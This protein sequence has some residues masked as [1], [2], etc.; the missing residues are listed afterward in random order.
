MGNRQKRFRL[1]KCIL[2]HIR[3]SAIR[4]SRYRKWVRV[5]NR[6]YRAFALAVS[7]F[8]LTVVIVLVAS[9]FFDLD[10]DSSGRSFTLEILLTDPFL[11]SIAFFFAAIAFPDLLPSRRP[12]LSNAVAHSLLYTL[13]IPA[14]KLITG[15]PR[16][17]LFSIADSRQLSMIW[18]HPAALAVLF[19]FEMGFFW[20]V[21]LVFSRGRKMVST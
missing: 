7:Y 9:L 13:L 5:R 12:S 18:F 14:V 11:A 8:F 4:R 1:G 3:D 16:H 6:C 15:G 20:V 17:T 21:K 19:G 2:S 10:R